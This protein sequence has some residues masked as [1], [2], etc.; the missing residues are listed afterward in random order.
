FEMD[1]LIAE[2]V[3]R[4]EPILFYYW[5]PNAVLSQFNFVPLDMGTYDDEAAKCL[6]RLAC[7]PLTPSA[8]AS[9]TVVVA[10]AEW[11]FADI[12]AIAAYFQRSSLPL[13]SM[14]ELLAQINEPGGSV[15][16]VAVL[17]VAV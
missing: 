5:Q 16:G 13:A 4:S 14:N 9:E 7:A 8:F 15:D 1:M 10:L 17:L 2:A 11:V 12:P 6:A 3:S